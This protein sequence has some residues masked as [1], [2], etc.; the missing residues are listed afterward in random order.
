MA[1]IYIQQQGAEVV[2]RGQRLR[3]IKEGIVL[4]EWPIIEVNKLV[5]QGEVKVTPPVRAWLL[6]RGI[7]VQFHSESL[8]YQ[9]RLVRTGS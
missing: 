8:S 1:V 9:G 7:D 2:K 5:L 6:S 4:Q 3:V